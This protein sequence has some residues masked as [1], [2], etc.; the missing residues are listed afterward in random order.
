[1]NA[2]KP[3]VIRTPL[4]KDGTKREKSFKLVEVVTRRCFSRAPSPLASLPGRGRK[5]LK[6]DDGGTE[7]REKRMEEIGEKDRVKER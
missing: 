6:D 1:M 2:K 7:A 5:R 4:H 3:K